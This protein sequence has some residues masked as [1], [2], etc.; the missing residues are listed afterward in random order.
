MNYWDYMEI[1]F[2]TAKEAIIKT[3]RQRTEW[4]KL[5]ANDKGLVSKIYKEFTQLNTPK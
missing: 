5:F 1:S 4:K 2:C 3:K